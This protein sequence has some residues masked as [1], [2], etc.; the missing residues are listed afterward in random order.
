M[1]SLKFIKNITQAFEH[2][3]LPFSS[4]MQQEAAANDLAAW[5]RLEKKINHHIHINAL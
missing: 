5:E 3:L 1:V 4:G 2:S